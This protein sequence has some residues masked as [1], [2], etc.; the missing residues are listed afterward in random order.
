MNEVDKQLLENLFDALDRL[1]DKECTTIDLYVLVYAT[2]KAILDSVKSIN[3][4]S[5]AAELDV[6]VRSGK[7]QDLQRDEALNL[8]NNLRVTLNEILPS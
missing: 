2:D 6:L 1:F 3:L 5:Y 4:R 8:T 7:P